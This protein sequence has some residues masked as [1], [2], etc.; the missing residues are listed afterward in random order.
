[1]EEL[2]FRGVCLKKL[3]P[4]LGTLATI[5]VT[6]LVF[7]LPH[8][9]ARYAAPAERIIFAVVVFALGPP[10]CLADVQNRQHLGLGPL[11]CRL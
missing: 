11:S 4:L 8:A 7:A 10:Q 9:G 1:M 2:W 5:L 6:A 3:R